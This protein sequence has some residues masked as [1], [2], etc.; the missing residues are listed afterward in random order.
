MSSR[1]QGIKLPRE[2]GYRGLSRYHLTTFPGPV[3][4]SKQA[5][6][7]LVPEYNQYYSVQGW[8]NRPT[9]TKRLQ[10]RRLDENEPFSRWRA[11]FACK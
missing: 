6:C 9:S 11:T 4:V 2:T 1:R 7:R 8:R 3:L 5:G 10:P